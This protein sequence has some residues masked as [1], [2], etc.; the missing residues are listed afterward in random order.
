MPEKCPFKLMDESGQPFTPPV[1]PIRNDIPPVPSTMSH[2]PIDERGYP[3]PFFVTWIKGQ[4]EFRAA[5][6]QAMSLAIRYG[7]CWVCGTPLRTSRVFVIGPMCCVNRISSEPP[8][9]IECGRYSVKACPFLT[10]PQMVRRENDLPTLL[11]DTGV[12]LKHNPGVSL[13]WFVRDQTGYDIE[14]YPE[15]KLWHFNREPAGV[16]W[17]FRGEAA[18]RQQVLDA[19]EVGLPTIRELSKLDGSEPMMSL[20]LARA[21]KLA[22]RY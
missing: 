1:H 21:M 10:K 19:I 6:R 17:W 3:V 12:A 4:P 5:N 8:S 20:W 11:P 16:E 7:L 2:L 9:H 14:N 13:L 22:P 18:T 15:G